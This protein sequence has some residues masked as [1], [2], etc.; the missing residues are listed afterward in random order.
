MAYKCVTDRYILKT[1]F[2]VFTMNHAYERSENCQARKA[3]ARV[4]TLIDQLP[5][6]NQ[7]LPM[8]SIH[9]LKY[10]FFGFD[11]LDFEPKN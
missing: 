5:I 7:D 2:V 3:Y 6:D 8:Y 11:Q 1:K 9:F 4:I 10:C